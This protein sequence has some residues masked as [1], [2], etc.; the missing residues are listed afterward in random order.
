LTAATGQIRFAAFACNLPI[1]RILILAHSKGF[2]QM[3]TKSLVTIAAAAAFIAA[4]SWS[5]GLAYQL[6]GPP[7]LNESPS[8]MPAPGQSTPPSTAMPQSTPSMSAPIPPQNQTPMQ[9][10]SVPSSETEQPSA[11]SSGS[12]C[13]PTMIERT[14][15]VPVLAWEKRIVPCVECTTEQ[16]VQNYT[17]MRE[18]PETKAVTRQYMVMVPET[19]T[20][21]ENYTVCKPVPCD[22]CGCC[23]G[24]KY[25][26]E[27]KQR[28][29]QY[30]VC[31]PQTR[32]CTYNVTVCHYV[33]EQRSV[34]VDV[35][36][37][38]MVNKEVSVCVCHMATKKVLV[39]APTCCWTP[40]GCGWGCGYGGGYC[41][42]GPYCGWGYGGW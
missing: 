7:G 12:C 32:Q 36:V 27:T 28:Q 10:P 3:K 2:R 33:P 9:Q 39:P 13:G 4:G 15:C 40:C 22:S 29:V 17:M 14:V 11:N 38:H 23:G 25:V 1:L 41:G 31:V 24:C 37:P 5:M 26:Q 21:T 34:T 6:P 16:R 8:S 20:R 42:G 35:C 30:T 18:V 19:R